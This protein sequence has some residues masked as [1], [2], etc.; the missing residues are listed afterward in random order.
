MRKL[1]SLL[2]VAACCA[3]IVTV[4]APSAFADDGGPTSAQLLASCPSSDTGAPPDGVG[5]LP[6]AQSCEWMTPD[7]V[8]HPNPAPARPLDASFLHDRFYL[9]GSS[10]V[11]TPVY[12]CGATQDNETLQFANTAGSSNSVGVSYKFE[13]ELNLGKLFEIKNSIELSYRHEWST[14]STTTQGV[15]HS[16]PGYSKG[17]ITAAP[18]MEETASWVHIIYNNQ[19]NGHWNYYVPDTITHP[20]TD[21]VTGSSEALTTHTMPLS[22]QEF[23]D[24]CP[25]GTRT[26]FRFHNAY[27][28][29]QRGQGNDCATGTGLNG[30]LVIAA[31]TGASKQNFV[32]TAVDTNLYRIVDDSTGGCLD[33]NG[34]YTANA[35]V[36]TSADV[37]SCDDLN[38]QTETWYLQ[39][40]Y[41]PGTSTVIGKWIVQNETG[42]CLDAMVTS[43]APLQLQH[44]WTNA[45]NEQWKLY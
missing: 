24:N 41:K 10:I 34:G 5:S 17:W 1:L 30:G 32:L 42:L 19:V 35:T 27:F 15:I 16:V 14:S 33:S 6:T 11:G 20:S 23:K 40:V 45:V 4:V 37:Y 39:D 21:P 44:C 43:S 28:A 9:G 3:A 13:M 29:N 26:K 38:P 7:E 31:C 25:S 36:G 2:A 22:A 12:N 18:M 8:A